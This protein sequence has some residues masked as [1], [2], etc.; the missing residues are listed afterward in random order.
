MTTN[1][2][3]LAAAF[4]FAASAATVSAQQLAPVPIGE[5][6]AAQPQDCVTDSW[7]RHDHGMEKGVGPAGKR[8]CE[9]ADKKADTTP[10]NSSPP[11]N[12][13]DHGKFHKGQ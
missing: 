5:R 2:K 1:M 6:P 11:K 7:P 13:H 9:G 8:V 10:A 3:R 4:V 12:R